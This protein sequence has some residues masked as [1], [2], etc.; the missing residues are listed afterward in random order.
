MKTQKLQISIKCCSIFKVSP[1]VS[2]FLEPSTVKDT[3]ETDCMNVLSSLGKG[4]LAKKK[5]HLN[6]P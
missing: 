4:Q 5:L 1:E 3:F 6:R 2:L